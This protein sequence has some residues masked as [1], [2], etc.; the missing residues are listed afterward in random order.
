MWEYN[1][2]IFI[3]LFIFELG[4]GQK[5]ETKPG[6]PCEMAVGDDVEGGGMV[7]WWWWWWWCGHLVGNARLGRGFGPKTWTGPLGLSLGH[8]VGN[9]SGGDGGDGGVVWTRWRQQ[10]GARWVAQAR[11]AVL[12]QKTKT[13]PLGLGLGC[14]IGNWCGRQWGDGGMVWWGYGGGGITCWAAQA[15]IARFGPKPKTSP[16]GLGLGRTVGNGNGGRWGGIVAW[17]RWGGG[18]GVV[19]AFEHTWGGWAKKLANR[20]IMAQFQSASGL[21]QVEGVLWYPRC[22]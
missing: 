21:Q 13:G 9:S 1:N 7:F 8:A 15:R 14:A 12:G 19:C 10:W 16:L 5:H 20:A 22:G 17:C 3:Y 4:L 11:V 6:V 18:S 2:L